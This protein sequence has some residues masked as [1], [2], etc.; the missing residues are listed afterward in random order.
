MMPRGG[1]PVNPRSLTVP[2]PGKY[3]DLL[4]RYD[5]EDPR[6]S[7][8][9]QLSRDRFGYSM[10]LWQCLTPYR[11]LSRN[12]RRSGGRRISIACREL[13]S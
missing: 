6:V 9:G 1:R 7:I 11:G 8:T 3:R 2:Q 4:P 10:G 5:Q 13:R 12:L